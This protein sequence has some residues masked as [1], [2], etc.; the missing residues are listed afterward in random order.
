MDTLDGKQ[1]GQASQSPVD[2]AI[3]GGGPAGLFAAFYAGLRKMSVKIIDS[4]D[5]LGGQL[6]TLY[7][8]KYIYDVPGFPRVLAKD[9]AAQLIQQGMQFGAIPCFGEHVRQ[10]DFDAE[11][12]IFALRMSAGVHWAR[13]VLIAAGVGAFEPK[14]LNIPDAD[15]FVGRGLY[16]FVPP[17]HTFRGRRVLIV[18]GGDSAVDWANMLTPIAAEVTVIHRSDRFRAHEESL[19]ELR[20]SKARVK[21]FCELKAIEGTYSAAPLSSKLNINGT[22]P[23]AV[24]ALSELP[25]A[26]LEPAAVAMSHPHVRSALIFDNRS[27]A[28][29]T[30][31]VDA[32]LVNIGFV[33]SLGALANWGLTLERGQIVVDSFMRASRPGVF[34]AGDVCT[35]PGKLKLI[36]TG[37][38]EACAAVNF[39]KQY[40]DPSA[41]AFPGH[42]TNMKK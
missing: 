27:G 18:G 16:Y 10:L 24:E 37:F 13:S 3:I 28:E 21:T 7:P 42:S 23:V 22:L 39:A 1:S 38:G 15:T 12:R 6:T 17:L 40:I 14:R 32:V 11:N 26:T 36:A 2:L 30:L 31:A 25:G 35:Y 20:D 9:L 19:Q 8:E 4:L 34:A 5:V 29:E 33:S 41:N